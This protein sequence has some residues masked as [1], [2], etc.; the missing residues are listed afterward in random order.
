MQARHITEGKTLNAKQ[1]K[2]KAIVD[3]SKAKKINDS[4][5]DVLNELMP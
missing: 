2:I 3:G 1:E 5:E 4:Q